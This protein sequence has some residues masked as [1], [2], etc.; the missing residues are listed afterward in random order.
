VKQPREKAEQ[1][2]TRLKKAVDDAIHDAVQKLFQNCGMAV[3]VNYD[4]LGGAE[5]WWSFAKQLMDAM[6]GVDL[7]RGA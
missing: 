3:Q 5:A 7:V 1:N 6:H 4:L 2:Q